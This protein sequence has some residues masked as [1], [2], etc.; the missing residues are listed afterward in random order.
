MSVDAPQQPSTAPWVVPFAAGAVPS[1]APGPPAWSGTP[2][3]GGPSDPSG[4]RVPAETNVPVDATIRTRAVLG[5]L[6]LVIVATGV[7]SIGLR[8]AG[9]HPP[10][11]PFVI[12]AK[13][14]SAAVALALIQRL[15]WIERVGLR[16]LTRWSF[17][18][19][20]WLPVAYVAIS[21]AGHHPSSRLTPWSTLGIV[22]LCAAVGLDEELWFRGLVLETLR[23]RGTTAAVLL[24]GLTFGLTHSIN[25]VGQSATATVGQVVF[26]GCFGVCL[27][28]VRVRTGSI[29]PSIALHMAWDLVLVAHEGTLDRGAGASPSLAAALIGS[30]IVG[31][32]LLVH[33]LVLVRRSRV[34][35]P[36][37][38][39]PSRRGQTGGPGTPPWPVVVTAAPTWLAPGQAASTMWAPPPG[40]VRAGSWP[41]PGPVPGAR[42]WTWEGARSDRAFRPDPLL[43]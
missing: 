11:L 3:A 37:G 2:P 20:A 10:A 24:S 15:G 25:I 13:L 5:L 23:A 33:G 27:G 32:P 1:P 30:L 22:V 40:A 16:R 9:A 41:S 38:R 7:W 31:S 18:W 26:A 21:A 29:W 42:G 28:A 6:A 4:G 17:L 34:C 19:L 43:E 14:A 35:G 36:D 12:G 8:L 39:L